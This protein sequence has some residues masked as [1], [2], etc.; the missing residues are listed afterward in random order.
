MI[1]DSII[2]H[3]PCSDG[4]A[5]AWIIKYYISLEAELIQCYAGK[6]PKY[7]VTY[8]A[9]KNVIFVDIYP[10]NDYLIELS[11]VAK[12]ICILDHHETNYTNYFSIEKELGQN[13]EVH[14]DNTRSGCMITWDHF[15]QG[16]ERPWFINYIGDRDL[17]TWKLENSVEINN[18][19]YTDD[20]ITFEGLPKLLTKNIDE[21]IERGKYLTEHKNKLIDA[22]IKNYTVASSYDGYY[23]Y[24]Y[25][26]RVDISSDVGN[27]LMTIPIDKINKLP[28]F[29]VYWRYDAVSKKYWLS[30]RSND[31]ST[32]V[33]KICQK[34]GGGGH[35]NASGCSISGD[36]I[37]EELFVPLE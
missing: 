31:N 9:N 21:F 7:D 25:T 22:N 13:V 16:K 10:P 19:L 1:Y 36:I 2:Y 5:S 11:K 35:R 34:Y 17:W 30:L 6:A 24:V 20:H 8:F 15:C 26:G 29:T 37:L 28:D 33:S 3:S 14:F 4:L 18:A 23:I 32:D 27:K 12:Y